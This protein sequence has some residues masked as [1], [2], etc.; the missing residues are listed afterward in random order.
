MHLTLHG[1]S[2]YV[3]RAPLLAAIIIH[4]CL[5]E[6]PVYIGMAPTR[7]MAYRYVCACICMYMYMCLCMTDTTLFSPPSPILPT[8]QGSVSL[9]EGG[10]CGC[11]PSILIKLS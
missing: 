7:S 4:E 6:W 8:G 11:Q 2:T 1:V 10:G 9:R 3:E 5:R